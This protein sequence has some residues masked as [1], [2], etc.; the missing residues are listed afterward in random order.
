MEKNSKILR[1][2]IIIILILLNVFILVN[3]LIKENKQ[4][5]TY[6]ENKINTN[7]IDLENDIKTE[8]Q[9]YEETVQ[10]TTQVIQDQ[11]SN[12]NEDERVQAY[13]GEFIDKIENKNYKEAY[14]LLNEEYKKQY[15]PNENDFENYVQTTYPKGNLAVKYNS[16]D[17]K[18]EI[19]TLSVTIYSIT[20]SDEPQLSQT[21]VIRENGVNDF[22]ISFSK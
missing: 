21:I 13:F 14:N 15:F 1:I 20:N 4:N 12:M 5:E 3:H 19:Y 6:I 16:F 9:I 11:I 22:K 8:N 10:N 7:I 17:R 2:L 18:G